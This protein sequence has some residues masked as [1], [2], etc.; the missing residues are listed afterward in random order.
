[1]KSLK[2]VDHVFESSSS[3]TPEFKAFSRAFTK[4]IKTLVPDHELVNVSVG[5][6]YISGFLRK[7]D[8]YV[9]FSCSDVRFFKN[10]W[11]N[12]LMIRLAKN[13]TDYTGFINNYT[14][15]KDIQA[16]IDKL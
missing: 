1:M 16:N 2:Y 11:Y 6:F 12:K 8:R 3:K 4:D 10:D 14:S 5:H 9:Y 7:N 15:L 13:E